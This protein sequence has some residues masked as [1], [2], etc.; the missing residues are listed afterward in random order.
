MKDDPSTERKSKAYVKLLVSTFST[1]KYSKSASLLAELTIWRGSDQQLDLIREG[2]IVRMNDLVVKSKSKRGMLQLSANQETPMESLPDQPSREQLIKAG[3]IP[4]IPKSLIQIN[5]MAKQ[6]IGVKKNCMTVNREFDVVACVVKVSRIGENTTVLYLT[7]ES[8]LIIKVKRDHKTDN[9]DVFALGNGPLPAVVA[10]KNLR[11]S[12]FDEDE[13]CAVATW[14]L[15]SC[16]GNRCMQRMCDD[17]HSWCTS[18][19]GVKCCSTVLDKINA[20]IPFGTDH[21]IKSKVCFGYILCVERENSHDVP[22]SSGAEIIIDYGGSSIKACLPR[23][24]LQ[25]AIELHRATY[26]KNCPELHGLSLLNYMIRY[27]QMLL[28]F[29]LKESSSYGGESAGVPKVV[30]VSPAKVKELSRLHL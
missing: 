2:S 21:F 20:G 11:M 27:N 1:K 13:H 17:L 3:Y 16:K 23:H 25:R 29:V 7:D 26:T 5:I 14:E 6:L 24:L 15:L 10:Y 4:R 8:G 30:D 9:S 12:S 19:S 22:T 18:D 28:R